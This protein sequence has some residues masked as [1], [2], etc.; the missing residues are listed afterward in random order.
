MKK[1]E[2]LQVFKFPI[3]RWFADTRYDYHNT[4]IEFDA[5]RQTITSVA[6]LRVVELRREDG[7]V[8]S[9]WQFLSTWVPKQFVVPTIIDDL[10]ET[11]TVVAQDSL[12]NI[13]K[14]PVCTG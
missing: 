8:L 5:D 13:I 7:L 9:S 14:E 10:Q 6:G 11:R 1:D 2:K 4:G 3:F 12:G